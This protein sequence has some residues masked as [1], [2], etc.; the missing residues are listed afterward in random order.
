MWYDDK[1]VSGLDKLTMPKYYEAASSWPMSMFGNNIVQTRRAA[2]DTS[3]FTSEILAGSRSN[4]N[5]P[6]A[7]AIISCG[8]SLVML[9]VLSKQ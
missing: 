5:R 8:L 1:F 6:E 9:V 2:I 4:L 7:K 3:E